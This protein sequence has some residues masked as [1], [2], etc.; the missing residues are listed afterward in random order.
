M[1]QE[2]P[3]VIPL[4]FLLA[5]DAVHNLVGKAIIAVV[6]PFSSYAL[7]LCLQQRSTWRVLVAAE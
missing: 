7:S 5:A 1:N 4:G 3:S 6:Q 2:I